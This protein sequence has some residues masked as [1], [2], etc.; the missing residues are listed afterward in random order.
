[1]EYFCSSTI[2]IWDL[3]GKIIT[4]LKIGIPLI[5][6]VLAVIDLGK[7][8]ISSK[9]D[10]MK[11]AIKTVIRRIIAGLVIFFIPTIVNVFFNLVGSFGDAQEDVKDYTVCSAC[12]AGAECAPTTEYCAISGNSTAPG[13]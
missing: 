13:C 9:E 5:I 4:I 8:S 10:E 1:M 11:T 2:E 7:A 6:I 12:I 3:L